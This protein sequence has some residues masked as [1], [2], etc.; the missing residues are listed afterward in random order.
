M[1]SADRG[2]KNT[3]WP[4]V[5]LAGAALF[6][7]CSLLVAGFVFIQIRKQYE[8]L[9]R[10]EPEPASEAAHKLIDY[11][12]PPGYQETR[13]G[14]YSEF[15]IVQIAP[16]S[17]TGPLIL[18]AP[19]NF[20]LI[21]RNAG[22]ERI[23]KAL[24]QNSGRSHL[25]LELVKVQMMIIRGEEAEVRTYEGKNQVKLVIREMVTSFPG[26]DGT[27]MMMIICPVALWDQQ[28]VD[29]FINSIH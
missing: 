19:V 23:R 12:L 2:N 8:R 1:I 20:S 22:Q 14:G 6:F 28:L 16:D 27:V 5:G 3:R 15:S 26:K 7:V 11:D 13:S 17:N 24:E 9:F 29:D 18:L 25:N 21:N 4:W 10:I